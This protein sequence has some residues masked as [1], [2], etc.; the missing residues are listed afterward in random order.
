MTG[1]ASRRGRR[2]LLKILWKMANRALHGKRNQ[3][4]EGAEGTIRHYLAK[5]GEQFQVLRSILIGDDLVNYFHATRRA[6]AAGRALAAA[7]H[8][9]K[10]HREA[11]LMR[12]IH[13]VVEDHH[14]AMAQH[15]LLFR[16]G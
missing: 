13:R 11:R 16:E 12:Q 4:A 9:A 2:R 14:S 6:D 7:F 1:A 15:A 10:F 3:S 8:G 5:I